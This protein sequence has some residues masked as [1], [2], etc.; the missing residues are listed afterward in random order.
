MRRTRSLRM[1]STYS[2]PSGPRPGLNR[3]VELRLVR[4]PAI[5]RV[6]VRGS[7]GH[8]HQ[9]GRR[10]VV[11]QLVVVPRG[12]QHGAVGQDED[13]GRVVQVDVARRVAGSA[14]LE[15]DVIGIV[16]A[17]AWVARADDRLHRPLRRRLAD[18]LV[19]PVDQ[20]EGPVAGVGEVDRPVER[21]L[22]QRMPVAVGRLHAGPGP[23]ADRPRLQRAG[24]PGARVGGCDGRLGRVLRAAGEQRQQ[25]RGEC[26]RGEERM[27]RTR[28]TIRER[29]LCEA[30]CAPCAMH[31]TSRRQ[32]R[33]DAGGPR[34]HARTEGRARFTQARAEGNRSTV[35]RVE[36]IP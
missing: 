4:R 10:V 8:V 36:S 32:G 24:L 6:S 5:A 14:Q 18:H 3:L 16:R 12:E 27:Q 23:G 13:V 15:R 30:D 35:G 7:A 1:S 11:P 34:T 26:G 19:V 2:A 21:G 9:A 28:V 22:E 33:S 25:Q 29:G 20:V 17:V 31:G